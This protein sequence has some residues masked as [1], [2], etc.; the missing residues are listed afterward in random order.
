[1]GNILNL[2]M[3]VSFIFGDIFLL[4]C[5][6]LQIDSDPQI[7]GKKIIHAHWDSTLDFWKVLNTDPGK[8]KHL[9]IPYLVIFKNN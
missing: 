8:G 5:I 1:M 9:L 3:S 2:T 7:E 4:L 6:Y